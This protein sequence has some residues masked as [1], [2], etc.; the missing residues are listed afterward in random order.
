MV[1]LQR[2]L[3]AWHVG[4]EIPCATPPQLLVKRTGSLKIR[5]EVSTSSVAAS[6]A[7]L[8]GDVHKQRPKNCKRCSADQANRRE[9]RLS[10]LSN[11]PH[12]SIF[13]SNSPLL[14]LSLLF[15][16]LLFDPFDFCVAFGAASLSQ[17]LQLQSGF[18]LSTICGFSEQANVCRGARG[19]YQWSR[20]YQIYQYF[21]K[22][23]INQ[24]SWLT[25]SPSLSPKPRVSHTASVSPYHMLIQGLSQGE[26]L[27]TSDY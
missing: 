3:G 14:A 22:N 9:Q 19:S 21:P 8:K 5:L 6:K 4:P 10:E 11:R 26:P 12:A 25:V 2:V 17:K 13:P 1:T 27:Q 15:D 23:S 7:W 20:I 18:G 24:G 16:R